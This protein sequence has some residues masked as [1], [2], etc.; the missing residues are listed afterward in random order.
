[1][2][3]VT[4]WAGGG[5][6]FLQAVALNDKTESSHLSESPRVGGKAWETAVGCGGNGARALL[7]RWGKA[8]K[9][10]LRCSYL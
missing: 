5:G 7:S 2:R 9:W 3:E 10:A 4:V 1:V 8:A 6:V